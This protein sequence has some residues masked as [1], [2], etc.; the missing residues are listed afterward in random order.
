MTP[1]YCLRLRKRFDDYHD[2]D[3]SPFLFHVIERHL[4]TCQGCREDY[5][6]LVRTIEAIRRFEAPPVP[7]RALRKVLESLSGPGGGAPLPERLFGPDLE[8]GLE[9][10]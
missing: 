9:P 7:P 4:K 2:R 1:P 6:M 3:L 8:Q 10:S 5:R